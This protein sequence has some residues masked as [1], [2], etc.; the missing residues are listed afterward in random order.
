MKIV[1]GVLTSK[2]LNRQVIRD[3]ERINKK[4]KK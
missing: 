1:F 2:N 4:I 3:A